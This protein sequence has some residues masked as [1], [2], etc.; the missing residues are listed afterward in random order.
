MTEDAGIPRYQDRKADLRRRTVEAGEATAVIALADKLDKVADADRAPKSRKLA[1]YRATLAAVEAAYGSSP[2]SRRLRQA[3]DRWPESLTIGHAVPVPP[4]RRRLRARRPSR[5]AEPA[6]SATRSRPL[7][8]PSTR[9][10]DGALATAGPR[11]DAAAVPHQDVARPCSVESPQG[12]GSSGQAY[13]ATSYVERVRRAPRRRRAAR[14]A[15]RDR[16][17]ALDRL[18]RRADERPARRRRQT[19]AQD[20]RALG[21]AERTRLDA[22][23]SSKRAAGARWQDYER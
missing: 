16:D 1:H 20:D 17:Q 9:L 18:R 10:A 13:A 12:R 2:L 3:L 5:R 14:C 8:R 4:C 23:R 11:S 21:F 7:A 6:R 15:E 19:A 22:K